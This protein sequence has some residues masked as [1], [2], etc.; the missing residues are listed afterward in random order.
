MLAPTELVRR[1]VTNALLLVAAVVLLV[2]EWLWDR[3]TEAFTHLGRL[4]VLR[5]LEAWCRARPPGQ[6][7]AL[8]VV[9]VAVVY[10]CKLLAVLA[11]G[12]GYVTLGLAAFVLAKVVATA[13]F[14][15]L[16]QLTEPAI[17]RYP[18]LRRGRDR[19]L[20][21]RRFVHCWL[22]RRPFYRQARYRVRTQTG[23]MARRY[24]AVYRLQ[25]Q[26]RR[27]AARGTLAAHWAAGRR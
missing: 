4:P 25:N 8:F 7:L 24:R 16:Y 9:P 11:M 13:L 12:M 5:S 18:S 14:A 22:N 2:E 20:R 15:R 1:C 27:A 3:S 23:R 17:M 10:P 6:A 21:A 19:F 26:R